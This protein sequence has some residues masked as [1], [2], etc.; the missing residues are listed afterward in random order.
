MTADVTH[1][2]VLKRELV[3]G[4]QAVEKVLQDGRWLRI[5]L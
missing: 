5:I 2:A 4:S 1:F 3:Q